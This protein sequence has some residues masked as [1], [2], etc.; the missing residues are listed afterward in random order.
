[1]LLIPALLAIKLPWMVLQLVAWSFMVE[2]NL[3]TTGSFSEALTITFSPEEQCKIC[4][5]ID[6][7]QEAQDAFSSP[8]LGYDVFVWIPILSKPNIQAA[9][10]ESNKVQF[11]SML[12]Q[13]YSGTLSP[14]PKVL[15]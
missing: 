15:S 14:P 8:A 1:M 4:E 10:S 12:S 13:W 9:H 3:Q 7:A 6:E 5:S 2:D 11:M